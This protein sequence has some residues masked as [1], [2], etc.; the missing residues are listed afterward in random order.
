MKYSVSKIALPVVTVLG[1]LLVVAWISG[2]LTE[3]ILPGSKPFA[4]V[5]NQDVFSVIKREQQVY[6][7]VPAGIEARQSTVIS[8]RILARI[9]KIHV[10]AGDMVTKGQVL[11]ELEQTDLQSRVSQ[12]EAGINSVAARLTEAKQSLSRAIDLTRKGLLASA[13]LNKT[14]ANHTVLLAGLTNA[15]QALREAKIAMS[16]AQVR[17]PI[18]G[19][20]VDRYAEPGDTAQPG[21]KLLSLYNPLSLGVEANV[22][23]QLALQLNN[24][25]AI[26]V[27]IPAL[28]ISLESKIE[29]LVPAGNVGSRSFLVKSRLSRTEGLVPG[30]YAKLHVPA[31]IEQSL[32]IPQARVA[33]IGQLDIVWV[34]S[35]AGVERRFVRVGKAYSDGMIE[36]ISGLAVGDKVLPVSLIANKNTKL[37]G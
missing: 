29:E 9:E 7:S 17:A 18:T 20:I 13:D 2:A 36:V 30:M 33:Q 16:F 32:V 34:Q 6:E 37:S 25:Q 11:I 4:V 28:D 31:G 14:Q 5:K 8:S 35:D 23:E 19:R 27:S 1:L 15:K 21:V 26:K 10:R 24:N 3:K 12:A 22:R